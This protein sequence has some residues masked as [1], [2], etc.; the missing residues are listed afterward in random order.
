MHCY[1]FDSLSTSVREFK[2]IKRSEFFPGIDSILNPD[3]LI[4]SGFASIEGP[5]LNPQMQTFLQTH[6]QVFNKSQLNALS[7]VTQMKSV[8]LMLI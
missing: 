6:S 7:K 1:Y 8:D 3:S 5:T 4:N 2:T